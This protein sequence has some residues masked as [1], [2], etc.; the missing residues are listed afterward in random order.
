MKIDIEKK[1]NVKIDMYGVIHLNSDMMP[2]EPQI[3]DSYLK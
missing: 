3:L 2:N 1:Y